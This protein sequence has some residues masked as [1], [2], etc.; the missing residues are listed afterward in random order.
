MHVSRTISFM[1]LSCSGLLVVMAVAVVAVVVM[2]ADSAAVDAASG[3]DAD[4]APP[5]NKPVVKE[6]HIKECS[7]SVI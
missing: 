7:E 4:C 5:S 2:L 3:A 6:T 1:Y